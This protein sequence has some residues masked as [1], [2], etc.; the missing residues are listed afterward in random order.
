M[1]NVNP[2]DGSIECYQGNSGYV[3]IEPLDNEGEPYFLE[4]GETVIFTVAAGSHIYIQKI[5]TKDDQNEKGLLN[6]FISHQDTKDMVCAKYKYD[7][8]F[9]SPKKRQYDT[10]IEP[11]RFE[12]K[13]ISSKAGDE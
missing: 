13:A 6:M 3:S 2:A 12:I 8:L 5:L 10:F 7:C 4:T 1:I 11:A 9:V